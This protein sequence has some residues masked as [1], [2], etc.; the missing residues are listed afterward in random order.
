MTV[1]EFVEMLICFIV[2]LLGVIGYCVIKANSLQGYAKL[3]KQPFSVKIYLSTDWFGISLSILAVL[4]WS[5]VF[6]ETM[7]IYPKIA[8]FLRLT[9]LGIGFTGSF[10][11]QLA[12]GKLKKQITANIGEIV[13]EKDENLER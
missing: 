3:Q 2:G 8:D 7:L 13:K 10:A 11:L 9:F 5:F 12:F 6:K 1:A 4:I